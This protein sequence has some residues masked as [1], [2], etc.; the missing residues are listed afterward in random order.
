MHNLESGLRDYRP[1]RE[2]RATP[3]EVRA[4][5]ARARLLQSSYS[6]LRSTNTEAAGAAAAVNQKQQQWCMPKELCIKTVT[7][8]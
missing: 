5:F 4:R 7:N 2:P 3:R 8:P 6:F 1:L